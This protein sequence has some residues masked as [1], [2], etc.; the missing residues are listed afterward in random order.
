MKMLCV[1]V[2]RLAIN[3]NFQMC[4]I[5]SVHG[6]NI[7]TDKLYKPCEYLVV[8]VVVVQCEFKKRKSGFGLF[9][10]M[11]LNSIQFNSYLFDKMPDKNKYTQVKSIRMFQ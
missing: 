3:V 10:C 6:F 7:N 5:S 1:D 8:V 4:C 9:C 11:D 2:H